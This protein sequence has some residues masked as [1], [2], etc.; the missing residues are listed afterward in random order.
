I[1]ACTLRQDSVFLNVL[2]FSAI[3]HI[4][5]ISYGIYVYHMFVLGFFW[6]YLPIATAYD[7]RAWRIVCSLVYLAATLLVADASWRFLEKPILA[8]KREA[9]NMPTAW[10]Q[11]AKGL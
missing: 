8:M 5:R 10:H 2:S 7:G 3:R 1:C 11:R 9:K 4:G 6:Q